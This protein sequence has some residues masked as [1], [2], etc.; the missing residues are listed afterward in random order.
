MLRDNEVIEILNKDQKN[1]FY[2]VDCQDFIYFVRPVHI[3]AFGSRAFS[4]SIDFIL[5]YESPLTRNYRKVSA[6]EL[7]TSKDE[8]QKQVDL[9]NNDEEHKKIAKLW[10]NYRNK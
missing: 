1:E 5:D 4:S 8:A 3:I 7:Y 9:L 6:R 2:I 10:N